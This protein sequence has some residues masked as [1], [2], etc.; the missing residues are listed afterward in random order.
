MKLGIIVLGLFVLIGLF[1]FV[2]YH[3]ERMQDEL[4][5]INHLDHK[6]QT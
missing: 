5:Q 2:W 4:E 6:D 1:L 3:I